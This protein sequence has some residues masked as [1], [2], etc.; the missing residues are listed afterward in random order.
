MSANVILILY[1]SSI[2]KKL[3]WCYFLETILSLF[4][5][6]VIENI[7]FKATAE[8]VR[9]S[10]YNDEWIGFKQNRWTIKWMNQVNDSMAHS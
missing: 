1:N 4:A 2:N 8:L 9:V 5:Q 6:F 7:T 10:A 3:I